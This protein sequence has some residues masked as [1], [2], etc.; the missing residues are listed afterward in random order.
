MSERTFP[1]E[2]TLSPAAEIAMLRCLLSSAE[3]RA[4]IHETIASAER[5]TVGQLAAAIDQIRLET[6]YD[7]QSYDGH[8]AID[9][10]DTIYEIVQRVLPGPG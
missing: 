7:S 1:E 2:N 3:E 5:F 4:G 8:W 6:D 9:R 10:L